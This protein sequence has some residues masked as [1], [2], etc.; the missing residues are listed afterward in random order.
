MVVHHLSKILVFPVS[1]LF[2]DTYPK[3]QLSAE[4]GLTY[5]VSIVCVSVSVF[6]LKEILQIF[7]NWLRCWRPD[8]RNYNIHFFITYSDSPHV[9]S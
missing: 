1:V 6:V 2:S 4:I 8:F 7:P 5:S 9:R 3:V